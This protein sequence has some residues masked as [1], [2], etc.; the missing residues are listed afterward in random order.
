M[1]FSEEKVVFINFEYDLRLS[2]RE[3]RLLLDGI[4]NEI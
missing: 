4:N 2:L 1:S 3:I